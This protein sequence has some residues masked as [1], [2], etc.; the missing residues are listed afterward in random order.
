MYLPTDP[1]ISISAIKTGTGRK[2]GIIL[3]NALKPIVTKVA[4]GIE[5]RSVRN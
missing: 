4:I 1:E 5:A 2:S 3:I